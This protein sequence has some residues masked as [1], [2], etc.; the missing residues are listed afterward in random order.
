MSLRL[1]EVISCPAER[2]TLDEPAGNREAGRGFL[3]DGIT[4][5]SQSRAHLDSCPEVRPVARS[6]S[7]LAEPAGRETDV[8][9][10]PDSFYGPFMITGNVGDPISHGK[11]DSRV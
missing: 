8:S 5:V 2:P 10:A 7:P 1:R 3:R 11:C 6:F 4:A 9:P